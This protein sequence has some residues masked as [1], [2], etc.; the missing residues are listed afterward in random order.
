MHLPN[1]SFRYLFVKFWGVYRSNYSQKMKKMMTPPR[2]AF[3]TTSKTDFFGEKVY[4]DSIM[5]GQPTPPNVQ[6]R[7]YGLIVKGTTW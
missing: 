2:M 5:D 4:K 6:P 3:G 7:R 1:H